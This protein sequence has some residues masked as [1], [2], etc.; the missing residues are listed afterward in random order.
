MKANSLQPYSQP[1]PPRSLQVPVGVRKH[2][3][4]KHKP[5]IKIKC[6]PPPPPHPHPNVLQVYKVLLNGVPLA[7]K[8]VVVGHDT[9]MQ[10]DFIKVRSILKYAYF[11]GNAN[12]IL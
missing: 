12:E 2:R 9:I 6:R 10:L 1:P 3:H 5:S 7:A 4:I 8:S 11:E